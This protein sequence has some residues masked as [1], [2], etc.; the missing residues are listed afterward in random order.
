MRLTSPVCQ[1]RSVEF[2][3]AHAQPL[4]AAGWATG[5][6]GVYDITRPSQ[7]LMMPDMPVSGLEWVVYL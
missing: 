4:L 5:Q 1:V 7:P 3:A 2:N 6:V